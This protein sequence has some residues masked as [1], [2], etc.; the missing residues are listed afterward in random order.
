MN[1]Y[2]MGET[3]F[4]GFLYVGTALGLASVAT[5]LTVLASA[6]MCSEAKKRLFR[7]RRKPEHLH[8][9]H[10]QSDGDCDWEGCPQLRDGEPERSGRSCP[11]SPNPYSLAGVR[12]LME[13]AE[14][15]TED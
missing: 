15:D 5:G 3:I 12:E 9:C 1:C 8:H 13:E 14:L 4:A 10:A 2:K 7:R 11:L 6:T